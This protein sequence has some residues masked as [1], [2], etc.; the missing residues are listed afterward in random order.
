MAGTINREADGKPVSSDDRVVV[1]TSQ[2]AG[3]GQD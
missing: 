2:P 3:G 1:I